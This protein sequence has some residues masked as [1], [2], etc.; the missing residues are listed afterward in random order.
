MKYATADG[1][2]YSPVQNFP[3]ADVLN[4]T[5]SKNNYEFIG[6]LSSPYNRKSE[7]ILYTIDVDEDRTRFV[8]EVLKCGFIVFDITRDPKEIPK[9]LDILTGIGIFS[10]ANNNCPVYQKNK[11][12]SDLLHKERFPIW[13][14]CLFVVIK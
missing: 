3:D 9:A 10:L 7:D 1:G 2:E 11:N 13:S 5:D 12:F 6:T 4:G 14:C 8:D